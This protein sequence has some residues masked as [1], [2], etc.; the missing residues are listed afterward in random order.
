MKPC[1]RIIALALALGMLALAGC[2]SEDS[3]SGSDSSTEAASKTDAVTSSEDTSSDSD[4]SSSEA[5]PEPDSS[6]E[7]SSVEDSS[8][9]DNTESSEADK[10]DNSNVWSYN[11]EC[12]VSFPDSWK[13]R[14]L[15]D[16]NIV[17]CKKVY[18]KIRGMGVLFRIITADPSE[19]GDAAYL[20]GLDNSGRYYFALKE[21]GW[22][23]DMTDQEQ[24]DE[25]GAM[26]KDLESVI[27]GI[28]CSATPDDEP[29]SFDG[30]YNVHAA[31]GSEVG[32]FDPKGSWGR[33]SQAT[34]EGTVIR[35]KQEDH[36]VTFGSTSDKNDTVSGKYVKKS[37][38]L[39]ATNKGL[40]FI[41]G[42]VYEYTISDSVPQIL[43]FEKLMGSKDVLPDGDFPFMSPD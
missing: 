30:Y 28:R 37:E 40:V 14:Y 27:K 35:F 29:I 23:I 25:F 43:T 31:V 1:K 20:V 10:P 42:S 4:G 13:D 9:P 38:G 39:K 19:M 12:T 24:V 18:D 32:G 11:G 3:D 33:V 41:G 5:P 6:S 8:D 36:S 26:M 17:Y 21:M 34:G 2:G 15:I 16:G 7:E 22:M